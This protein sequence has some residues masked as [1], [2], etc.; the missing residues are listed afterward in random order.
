[1]PRVWSRHPPVRRAAI[2]VALT[3]LLALAAAA[4]AAA[5]RAA[6]LTTDAHCY[7]QGA[8]LRMTAGGL[9][10][11]APLTVALDGRA[12]RYRNGSTPTADDAGTFGSS[13]ATP[14]LAPGV[15]QQRHVLA[16]GD[17][18]HRPQ[19]RFTV[20]RRAGASFQPSSGNPRTL[21]ARF[22]VWGFALGGGVTTAQV[23]LHWVDP[24]GKVRTSAAIGTTGGDCGALTT[25]PRRVFPFDPEAG[26]W[27]L[28][29]DTHRRYRVQ[30]SGP[31]AKIPVHVRP[32][33]L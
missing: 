18:T 20:T 5:A 31:R 14:A 10:P 28:V 8:P 12:L 23:W 21:R 11:K 30:T 2:G 32:L 22:T 6:T 26:R 4:G 24:T 33:S 15:A 3:C 9:A 27:V 1:M 17:G 19:A 16:V 7:L 29:L 13:F 25:A